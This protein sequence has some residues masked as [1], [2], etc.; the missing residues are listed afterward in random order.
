[1]AP[2]VNFFVLVVVA[3]DDSIPVS[4]LFIGGILNKATI[5]ALRKND[6]ISGDSNVIVDVEAR[7]KI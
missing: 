6:R 5:E 3:V 1:M 2:H 4:I 7:N